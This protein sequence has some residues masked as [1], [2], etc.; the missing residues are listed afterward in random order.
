MLFRIFVANFLNLTITNQKHEKAFIFLCA[1][2]LIMA[3]SQVG[4]NTNEPQASL[5]VQAAP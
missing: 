1:L 4:I 2:G 3:F 5:D